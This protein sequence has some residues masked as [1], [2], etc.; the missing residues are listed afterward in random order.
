MALDGIARLGG[1]VEAQADPAPQAGWRSRIAGV[2]A[3]RLDILSLRPRA[4]EADA[5]AELRDRL[6]DMLGRLDHAPT[7]DAVQSLWRQ[8]VPAAA[9]DLAALPPTL[10]AGITGVVGRHADAPAFDQLRRLARNEALPER[11]RLLWAA[12]GAARDAGLAQQAIAIARTEEAPAEQSPWLLASV[13][14][15]GHRELA[16]QALQQHRAEVTRRMSPQGLGYLAPSLLQG[17]GDRRHAGELVD[18]TEREVGAPGLP[19]AR[20]AADAIGV[21]ARLVQNALPQLRS[22]ALAPP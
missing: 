1:L 4:G 12:I 22:W 19:Q 17:S 7:V 18:W 3:A 14:D 6:I 9:T 13:A 11:R 15:A 2:L 20:K 8:A 21:N 5:D 16:W 10:L